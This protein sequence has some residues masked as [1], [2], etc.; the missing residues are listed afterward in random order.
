[1]P[2]NEIIGL[3]AGILTSSSLIPQIMKTLK[4]K[5]AQDISFKML[6]VLL[7]GLCL[8]IYYGIINRDRP[9]IYTNILAASITILM[10]FLKY[11]YSRKA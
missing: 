6:L 11:K 7:I 4:T 1:M 8:W 3:I 5:D 10:I 2:F 9:I